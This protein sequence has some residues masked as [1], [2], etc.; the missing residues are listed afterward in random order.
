MPSGLTKSFARLQDSRQWEKPLAGRLV[1][2]PLEID[3][4]VGNA[5]LHRE[6]ALQRLGLAGTEEDHAAS[7]DDAL[8]ICTD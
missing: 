7:S 1:S 3:A 8:S 4:E 2:L 6:V 5:P